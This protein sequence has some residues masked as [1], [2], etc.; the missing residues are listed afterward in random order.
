[1]AQPP[2]Q[3]HRGSSSA[4]DVPLVTERRPLRR[5]RDRAEF[6]HPDP[7]PATMFLLFVSGQLGTVYEIWVVAFSFSLYYKSILEISAF[8]STRQESWFPLPCQWQIH[9]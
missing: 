8:S 2:N 6:Q 1:M 4:Y 9:N 3:K 5:V 7:D